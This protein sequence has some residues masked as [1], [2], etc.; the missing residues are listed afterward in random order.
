MEPN[1]KAKRDLFSITRNGQVEQITNLEGNALVWPS[2][3]NW[4]P[5][6]LKIAL[7]SSSPGNY[8]EARLAVFDT[9]SVELTEYCVTVASQVY[10]FSQPPTPIWSPDGKQILVIDRYDDL[11]SQV[12]L[13]DM[14]RSLIVNITDDVEKW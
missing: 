6:G 1:G 7:F 3:H 9:V 14:E 4:S 13:I 2:S 8:E 5:D 12:F 10:G 11:R